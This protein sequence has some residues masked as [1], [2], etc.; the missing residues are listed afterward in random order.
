MAF[1]DNIPKLLILG[2]AVPLLVINLILTS[3][4]FYFVAPL[5]SP[6]YNI[7]H[8]QRAVQRIM[9]MVGADAMA[10][11]AVNLETN[12]RKALSYAVTNPKDHDTFTRYIEIAQV[13][14]FTSAVNPT[15]V[16]S[17]LAGE[18]ICYPIGKSTGV[19][20]STIVGDF[21]K[22][23]PNAMSCVFPVANPS[24]G[25]LNSYVLLIWKTPLD[26]EQQHQVLQQVK[27]AINQR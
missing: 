22:E 7:E 17:L 23:S 5:I 16:Q 26:P 2:L 12:S 27:T 24:T 13:M 4:V 1:F 11:W 15:I 18:G 9:P 21:V 3:V 19:V 6:S 20:A 14:K 8:A 10:I 25:I